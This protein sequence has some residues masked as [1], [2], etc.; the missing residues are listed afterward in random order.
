M[1]ALMPRW[2]GDL[3]GWFDTDFP[4][5]TGH[6]IRVEDSLTDTEY[7]LRA[8]LPGLDPS[9]DITVTVDQDFLTVSAERREEEH[10]RGRTEFRYGMLQRSIRLP[11]GADAEHITA[12][13]DKGILTVK[14]PLPAKEPGGRQIPI[15]S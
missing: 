9:K 12:A 1:N 2:I 3:T 8:E 11:A 15:T 10:V 13:Y 14:V 6:M 5:R 4:V 7:I